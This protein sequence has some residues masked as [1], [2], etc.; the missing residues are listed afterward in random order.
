MHFSYNYIYYCL[1][2]FCVPN[3]LIKNKTESASIF[4]MSSSSYTISK[5]EGN[6]VLYPHLR[7]PKSFWGFV[8]LCSLRSSILLFIITYFK[9]DYTIYLQQVQFWFQWAVVELWETF[10]SAIKF[11]WPSP[12]LVWCIPRFLKIV[13]EN[14]VSV[15]I[16]ESALFK[17]LCSNHAMV[18]SYI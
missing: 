1:N 12:K 11:H 3:I 8:D 18:Y 5:A 10:S 16:M 13:R 4:I 15:V 6:K 7:K 9:E 17:M 2:F 14:C